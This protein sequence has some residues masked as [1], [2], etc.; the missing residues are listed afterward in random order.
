MT[1]ELTRMPPTC[2]TS[3]LQY[4]RAKHR[5]PSDEYVF[6]INNNT[7]R[8]QHLLLFLLSGGRRNVVYYALPAMQDDAEFISYI[9]HLLPRTF[10]VDVAQILPQ[11]VGFQRHRIILDSQNR[12]AVLRS[13]E[14]QIEVISAEQYEE[15]IAK[16][17]LG[18]TVAE[19]LENM[20]RPVKEQ[21]APKSRQAR[22]LFNMLSGN[23]EN[24]TFRNNS[25]GR[26]EGFI[27]SL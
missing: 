18:I 14:T 10:F 6:E 7:Y 9:P 1:P 25:N 3:P 26:I 5:L 16:K 22:F 19:L 23:R 15:L 17:K 12:S 13:K 11:Q 2:I 8:D 4:K 20:K 24:M 27:D 21:Y